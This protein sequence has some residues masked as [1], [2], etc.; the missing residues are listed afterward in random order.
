MTAHKKGLAGP[1]VLDGH[2]IFL[3]GQIIV[4]GQVGIY[5][6]IYAES[7][8]TEPLSSCGFRPCL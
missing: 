5:N 7:A 1:S 4:L 6:R 8:G 2:L 3:Q